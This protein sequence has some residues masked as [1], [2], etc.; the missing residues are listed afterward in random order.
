MGE[1]GP[2][3]K[4]GLSKEKENSLENLLGNNAVSRSLDSDECED[5]EDKERE[6]D[7]HK[8]LSERLEV[9]YSPEK[10]GLISTRKC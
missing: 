10:K 4:K 2:H 6:D 8:T 9:C 1:S 7:N 3:Y 5:S